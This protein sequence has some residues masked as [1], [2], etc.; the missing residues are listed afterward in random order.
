MPQPDPSPARPRRTG[1]AVEAAQGESADWIRDHL[2]AV[3]RYA[4]RRLSAADADDVAAQ[5]FEALFR[6]EAAGR[7]PDDAGAYLFGVA[8]R[9]VADVL[10]SRVR[11]PEPVALPEGWAGIA[12]EVLPDEAVESEE[13]R[14]LVHVALGLLPEAERAL[15]QARYRAGTSVA[16]LAER[17]GVSAK[18]VEMRLRRARSAFLTH[19]R[20]IGRDW[21]DPELREETAP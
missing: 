15:M 11:R 20:R 1:T 14:E 2:D 5:A 16:E 4:R 18:A 12:D 8:R 9:R 21:L 13:L 17:L 10:R 19:F 7:A 3:Y 6:A